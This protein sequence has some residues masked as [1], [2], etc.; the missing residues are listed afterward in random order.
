MNI[1]NWFAIFKQF[2][3]KMQHSAPII[4]LVF[5]LDALSRKLLTSGFRNIKYS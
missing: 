4:F 5:E 3:S 1:S 2:M